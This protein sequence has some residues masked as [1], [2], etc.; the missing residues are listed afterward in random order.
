MHE[1]VAA[2]PGQV[3]EFTFVEV[4]S[5]TKGAGSCCCGPDLDATMLHL[6]QLLF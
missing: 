1:D 3:E 6:S 4:K 2:Q 5:T